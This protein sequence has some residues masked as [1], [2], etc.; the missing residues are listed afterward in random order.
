MVREGKAFEQKEGRGERREESIFLHCFK[1][2]NII[3]YFGKCSATDVRERVF[4]GLRE[5]SLN[6]KES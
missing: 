2:K 4:S 6:L 5:A 1:R 3:G